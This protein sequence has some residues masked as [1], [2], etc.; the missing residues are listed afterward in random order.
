MALKDSASLENYSSVFTFLEAVLQPSHFST[1]LEY[2]IWKLSRTVEQLRNK[3]WKPSFVLSM[4]FF[5]YHISE[6]YD[7]NE[8]SDVLKL[9]WKSYET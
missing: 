2:Q 4:P 9:L 6:P 1:F 5:F 8:D 7:G 3:T